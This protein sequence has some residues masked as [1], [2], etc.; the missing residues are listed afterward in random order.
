M[1]FQS[2]DSLLLQEQLA[3]SIPLPVVRKVGSKCLTNVHA[4]VGS[5]LPLSV[6]RALK[7]KSL[8]QGAKA[9]T[10]CTDQ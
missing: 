6:V 5:Y 7:A 8:P 1:P 9:I 3:L 4:D 2:L 10:D